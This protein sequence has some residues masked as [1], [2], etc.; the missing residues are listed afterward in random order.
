MEEPGSDAIY[1]RHQEEEEIPSKR[2]HKIIEPRREKTGFCICE[3]KDAD[4]L[5]G[6][7]EADQRLCFCYIDSTIHLLSKSEN[8]TLNIYSILAVS[9]ENL[10]VAYAQTTDADQL[11][12]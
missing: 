12:Y 4:Q 11:R 3:N 7:R 6:N 2:T 5:R 1:L 10:L 9:R 8:M